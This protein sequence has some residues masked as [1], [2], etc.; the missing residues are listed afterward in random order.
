MMNSCQHLIY[1]L[2]ATLLL[3]GS[4][5]VSAFDCPVCN[6]PPSGGGESAYYQTPFTSSGVAAQPSPSFLPGR[7]MSPPT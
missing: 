6:T 4:S 1:C 5:L 7:Q 2:P 3:S